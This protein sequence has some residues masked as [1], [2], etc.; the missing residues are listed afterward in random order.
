MF[1]TQFSPKSYSVKVLI[2]IPFFIYALGSC[3][4]ISAVYEV[5]FAL[6]HSEYI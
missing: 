5:D 4:F 3:I 1:L 6:F 2:K